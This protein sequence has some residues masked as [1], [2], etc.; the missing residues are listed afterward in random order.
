MSIEFLK[1]RIRLR[2]R[3]IYNSNLQDFCILNFESEQAISGRGGVRGWL[4]RSS[5]GVH[6]HR[7]RPAR[8]GNPGRRHA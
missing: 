1:V 8:D 3:Q 5:A 2:E 4:Q 7:V 6:P